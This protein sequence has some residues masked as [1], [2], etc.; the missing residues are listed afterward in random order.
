MAHPHALDGGDTPTILGY[1]AN[2]CSSEIG[3]MKQRATA[4]SLSNPL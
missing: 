3:E 2:K 4:F 1:L